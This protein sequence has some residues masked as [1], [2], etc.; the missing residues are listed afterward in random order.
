MRGKLGGLFSPDISELEKFIPEDSTNFS[1]FV[2][3]LVGPIEGKGEESF[4]FTICTSEWLKDKY[5]GEIVFL[6][7]L[8]LVDHFDFKKIK[9]RVEDLVRS[10][11]GKDWNDFAIQ[12]SRYGHWEFENYRQ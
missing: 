5:S 12:L 4:D 6:R 9:E 2:Q 8:I 10:L 11:S 1:I 3:A 7:N